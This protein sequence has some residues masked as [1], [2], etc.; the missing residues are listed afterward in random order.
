MRKIPIL[1]W[2]AI[3]ATI[4]PTLDAASIEDHDGGKA[5]VV[6]P[7]VEARVGTRQFM[8]VYANRQLFEDRKFQL[9]GNVQRVKFDEPR[10]A[11]FVEDFATAEP[12]TGAE[13]EATVNFLPEPM[14]EISPGAYVT[15]EIILGGGRNEVEIAYTIGDDSG[16]LSMLLLVAGGE[17]AGTASSAA[18]A[19][20]VKPMAIPS[21][22]FLAAAFAIYAAAGGLFVLRRSRIDARASGPDH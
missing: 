22:V 14:S 10:L 18:A 2:A 4:L 11:L 7:R 9:F 12:V 13:V 5:I 3:A 17:S 8:L 15:Q 1:A 16:T 6:A 19:S 21:W 20:A